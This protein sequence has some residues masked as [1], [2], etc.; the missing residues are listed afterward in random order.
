MRFIVLSIVFHVIL[1]LSFSNIKKENLTEQNKKIVTV[2]FL[3]DN[4]SPKKDFVKQSVIQN[5]E[6]KESKVL[7]EVFDKVKGDIP[8]ESSKEERILE[9]KSEIQNST[10]VTEMQ[11]TNNPEANLIVSESK[12]TT[13]EPKFWEILPK[14]PMYQLVQVIKLII[15]TV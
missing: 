10:I 6:S 9:N 7:K 5:N 12:P 11:I 15:L 3:N 13:E 8:D 14:Y 4:L 1:F 2:E